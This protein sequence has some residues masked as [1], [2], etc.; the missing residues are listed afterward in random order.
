MVPRRVAI[1][2][3]RVQHGRRRR[4]RWS[5]LPRV[6][7]VPP[8]HR[9]GRTPRL[10]A[11]GCALSCATCVA[12]AAGAHAAAVEA[13]SRGA[14]AAFEV[15]LEQPISCEVKQARK[16]VAVM[17]RKGFRD[18]AR[19]FLQ[20]YRGNCA[21]RLSPEARVALAN[22]EALLHFHDDDD[23]ACLRALAALP[24]PT[25]GA[26]VWNRALCGGACTLP[27]AKC[28]AAAK[29]RG[30]ALAGRELRAK[31]RQV[32]QA[33][34]WDCRPG[35]PCKPPV[36]DDGKPA[37]W[38]TV[39]SWDLKSARDVNGRGAVGPARKLRWTGDLNGDG[40][41]D[42]IVVTRGKSRLSEYVYGTMQW[43]G[44]YRDRPIP[45]KIFDVQI[46]CGA[47][48]Q[49]E[50]IWKEE[51]NQEP[52]YRDTGTGEPAF[53]LDSFGISV[54]ETTGSDIPAVC[55]ES[56]NMVVDERPRCLD[57]SRWNSTAGARGQ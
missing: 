52:Y 18:Q 8:S 48:G 20:K 14:K 56:P 49:F 4:S 11:W 42:F 31:R 17:D 22:D 27:P 24:E 44:G 34:C 32:T 2:R 1:A 9:L 6:T 25:A 29:T 54:D 35:E 19:R 23:A 38:G 39:I 16:T 53:P 36:M 37:R 41:G 50:Q 3:C 10:A 15:E 5:R 7:S 33:L 40:F 51:T 21:E 30:K 12:W 26:T 57:L 28:E 55:I 43:E 47:N 13:D 46:G 45:Y